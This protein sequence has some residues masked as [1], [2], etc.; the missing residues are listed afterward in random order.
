MLMFQKHSVV[1]PVLGSIYFQVSFV[2]FLTV[3]NANGTRKIL[4]APLKIMFYQH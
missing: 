2:L 3:G 1:H 4:L